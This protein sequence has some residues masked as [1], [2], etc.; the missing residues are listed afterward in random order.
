[1]PF[2]DPDVQKK[3]AA[4]DC[5]TIF[6]ASLWR[7]GSAISL[8]EPRMTSTSSYVSLDFLLATESS[9]RILR[10]NLTRK[11]RLSLESP[12]CAEPMGPDSKAASVLI[13]PVARRYE[14]VCT[15]QR[16]HPETR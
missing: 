7:S 4:R 8:N 6:S 10:A 16:L 12:P 1:M 15:R 5:D 9:S 11:V 14:N 2:V 3:N 13:E